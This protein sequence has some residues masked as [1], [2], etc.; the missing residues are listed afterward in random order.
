[1]CGTVVSAWVH[2]LANLQGFLEDWMQCNDT[3][4]SFKY[5][6]C[7]FNTLKL[8]TL[9]FVSPLDHVGVRSHPS[10]SFTQQCAENALGKGVMTAK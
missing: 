8:I 2:I 7:F 3:L 5:I 4:N 10:H 1:M 6:G 9:L